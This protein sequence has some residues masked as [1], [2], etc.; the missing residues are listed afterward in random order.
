M[1]LGARGRDILRIL[2]SQKMLPFGAGAFAGILLAAAS[3]TVMRRL[4]YGLLP[5]EVLSFAL[6]LLPSRRR[7][8]RYASIPPR[9]CA[10]NKLLRCLF[11]FLRR[12]RIERDP[13]EDIAVTSQDDQSIQ[14]WILRRGYKLRF[15]PLATTA[16]RPT[17]M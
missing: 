17:S 16:S 13:A 9:L 12:C 3:A 14:T 6:W 7:A 2:L 10:T 1:A 8:A 15:W 5:F 4:V 11:A